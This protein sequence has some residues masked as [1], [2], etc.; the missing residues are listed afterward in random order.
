MINP[1]GMARFNRVPNRLIRQFAGWLPGFGVIVH[2]GRRSGR[3]YRTPVAAIRRPGGYVV[4]LPY[5][6][7]DWTKNVVAAGGCELQKRRGLV[8]LTNPR[9]VHDSERRAMPPVVRQ[10]LGVVGVTEFVYL[11]RV[12]AGEP[13]RPG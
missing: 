6:V 2:R 13:D 11:D 10:L 12:A 9:L 7:G 3:V 8:R 5:G 1:R 4:A